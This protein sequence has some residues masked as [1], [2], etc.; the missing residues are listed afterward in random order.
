MTLV[1]IDD[2]RY[3]VDELW[4]RRAQER[5]CSIGLIRH[6]QQQQNMSNLER[7]TKHLFH[8]ASKKSGHEAWLNIL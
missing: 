5:T 4:C 2:E 8:L 6:R 1:L 7:T 3:G